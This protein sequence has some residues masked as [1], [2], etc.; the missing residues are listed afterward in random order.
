MKLLIGLLFLLGASILAGL[1]RKLHGGT[2]LPQPAPD[3]DHTVQDRAGRW[4]RV[5]PD[6]SWEE[7]FR[8]PRRS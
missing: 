2:F 6:G 5:T 1:W 8:R 7:A 3:D 4:W